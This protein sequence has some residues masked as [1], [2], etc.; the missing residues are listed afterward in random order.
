MAKEP[1]D[2]EKRDD[3]ANDG[4]DDNEGARDGAGVLQNDVGCHDDGKSENELKYAG[5]EA[6][7]DSVFLGLDG[8][9]ASDDAVHDAAREKSGGG[10]AAAE[11][12][13]GANDGKCESDAAE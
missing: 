13:S 8:D 2:D 6:E 3:G 9:D 12:A 7:D 11:V 4:D 5:E 10:F 1:A